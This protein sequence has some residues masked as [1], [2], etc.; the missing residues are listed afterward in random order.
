MPKGKAGSG[1]DSQQRGFQLYHDPK[2]GWGVRQGER[3]RFCEDLTVQVTLT[4]TFTKEG[5]SV[6]AG[7]GVVR[8][9]QRGAIVITA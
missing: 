2:K 7:A 4:S 1:E 5:L 9:L 3:W 8:T 6:L